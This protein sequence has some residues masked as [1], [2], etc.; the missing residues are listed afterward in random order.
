[1]NPVS[2]YFCDVCD[3]RG[4]SN[5]QRHLLIEI[6]TIAL[7]AMLSGAQSFTD[8][9]GFGHEK[10]QW[11]RERLGLKL[12][13]GIPSHD[14]F[15]RLFASVNPHQM[16]QAMQK[17]TRALHQE[18]QGQVIALDGKTLRR[19]FNTA[20][21]KAA[22]HL[23]NAWASESRLVLA[24]CEVDG[25][26]NE[27]KAM[28]NLLELLDIRGCIVTCDALN[29]QKA[30]AHQIIE[31]GGDY[32]LAL[33]K[34]HRLLY[35]EV[36]D[37]FAWGHTQAGGLAQFSDSHAHTSEWGHG[38]HEV[39]RCFVIEVNAQDWPRAHEQWPELKSLVLVE[40]QRTPMGA[41]TG[42]GKESEFHQRFYLSSLP[43]EAAGLLE[44]VRLHWGVEN[45]AHWC[46]GCPLGGSPLMKTI[47]GCAPKMRLLIWRSGGVCA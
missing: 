38:R 25:K 36:R 2:S 3:P 1:M 41:E 34:N 21:G 4:T 40:A 29:T 37:Y 31:Q 42:A 16:G 45:Q 30:I 44:A 32:V 10:Q 43:G 28:P 18:T 7:C 11:L 33:K 39:R 26:S 9:E 22:L 13:G 35:E 20:T 47:A 15:G 6:L 17:W 27:M 5:A 14:T 19:S 12:P 46:L 24:Q 23:V 8:M